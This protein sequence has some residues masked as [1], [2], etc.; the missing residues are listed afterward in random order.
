MSAGPLAD[1]LAVFG[2][3][4]DYTREGGSIPVTLTFQE[5]TQ[6]PVMLLPIGAADDMAHSQNEKIDLKNYIKGTQVL[7]AFLLELRDL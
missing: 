1:P 7:A 4:P 2:V 6:K 3:K 5:I